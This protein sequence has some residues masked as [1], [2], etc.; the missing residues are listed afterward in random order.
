MATVPPISNSS[1]QA[2]RSRPAL[3]DSLAAG[4]PSGGGSSISRIPPH[5]FEA[6]ESLLGAMLLSRDAIAVAVEEVSADDFYKPSHA[7]V[8]SAVK[9]R[10]VPPR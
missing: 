9:P 6:E 5:S 2:R 4:S 3:A 7:H 8:F 10:A 1:R